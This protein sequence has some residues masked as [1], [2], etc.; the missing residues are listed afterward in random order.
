M[1]ELTSNILLIDNQGLS[2]IIPVILPKDWQNI[3]KSHYLDFPKKITMI[4][5]HSR[6]KIYN[7]II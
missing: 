3:D 5:K 1:N 7:F 6:K 2:F 4:P